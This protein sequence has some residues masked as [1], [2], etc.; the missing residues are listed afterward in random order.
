VNGFR[1][2]HGW[3]RWQAE[4]ASVFGDSV[5]RRASI[6]VEVSPLKIEDL[7][8]SRRGVTE[9]SYSR[10]LVPWLCEHEG[11]ALYADGADMLCLGDV[12]EL[13]GLDMDAAAVMVVKHEAPKQ[14]RPR[15]WA[16]LMLLN[17]ARLTCWT[18]ETVQSWP[19]ASLMRFQDFP[20]ASIGELPGEWNVLMAS[21]HE[22]PPG[23]KIAHWSYLSDPCGGGW[24]DRSGSQVWAEAREAWRR[25]RVAAA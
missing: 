17:C 20:D 6:P 3:D 10:F 16:S 13:A 15:S 23:T 14:A 19:D 21:P 11:R 22:P 24:I 1:V 8:I 2:F 25:E 12:A 7:P 4:A 18:P 9:F 5:R